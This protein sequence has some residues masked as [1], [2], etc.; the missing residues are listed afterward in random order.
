MAL[1][2]VVAEKETRRFHIDEGHQPPWILWRALQVP[3]DVGYNGRMYHLLPASAQSTI[4][5][6]L[7]SLIAAMFVMPTTIVLVF[8]VL[9][10][11]LW[12]L[13]G[14]SG[15]EHALNFVGDAAVPAAVVPAKVLLATYIFAAACFCFP[16]DLGGMVTGRLADRL[17][18]KV[19]VLARLWSSL[20][21]RATTPLCAPNEAARPITR[22]ERPGHKI[23]FLVGDTPQLE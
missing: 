14:E 9:G 15:F 3:P 8:A 5:R 20:V 18:T 1:A 23:S 2:T 7:T 22:W 17:S 12:S 10:Y 21:P 13:V 19:R 4:R 16:G 6:E 11:V